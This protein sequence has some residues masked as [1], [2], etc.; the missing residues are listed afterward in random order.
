MIRG[1]YTSTSGMLCEQARQDVIANNLANVD[2]TGFKKDIAVFRDKPSMQ[3]HRI[4]DKRKFFGRELEIDMRPYI[5]KLGTGASVDEIRT[6]HTQGKLQKTDNNLDFAIVGEGMFAVDTEDGIRYTRAGN[7]KVGTNGYLVDAEGRNVMALKEPAV[8]NEGN[9]LVDSKGEFALNASY[10]PVGEADKVDVNEA[11]QVFINGNPTHRLMVVK[12]DK[13]KYMRKIGYNLYATDD[14]RVGY[15]RFNDN[16]KIEQ[17]M[18]EKSNV[19][20][21]REMV[22]MITVHR[23]YETNQRCITSEDSTLGRLI[24][25]V[26]SR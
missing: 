12:F 5:G 6:I 10:V 21:V 14:D 2:T 8:M 24:S 9:I 23:A 4:D 22:N 17:G 20:I 3:M 11:G 26:G 18:L 19:N 7:F 16:T 13:P 1:I 25:Q 15:G